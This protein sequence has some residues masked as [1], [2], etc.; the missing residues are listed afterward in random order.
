MI[1]YYHNTFQNFIRI[2][3]Y[4]ITLVNN[5]HSSYIALHM[6]ILSITLNMMKPSFIA[7]TSTHASTIL[8]LVIKALWYNTQVFLE[9]NVFRFSIL[10]SLF[11]LIISV[12]TI[13]VS[14]DFIS[15]IRSILISFISSDLQRVTRD[16][17][18]IIVSVY[19]NKKNNKQIFLA[20]FSCEA[21]SKVLYIVNRVWCSHKGA[22]ASSTN[23]DT[24]WFDQRNRLRES[25]KKAERYILDTGMFGAL[26]ALLF[27]RKKQPRL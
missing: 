23:A 19:N 27:F 1:N 12:A 22:C 17:S 6:N 9:F 11:C 13:V 24:A 4:W 20:L 21:L 14:W 7:Y 25:H 2:T 15:E 16:M 18:H 3:K 8:L 26:C 10:R 5:N